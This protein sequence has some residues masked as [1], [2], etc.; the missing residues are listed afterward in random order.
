M[1]ELLVEKLTEIEMHLNVKKTKIYGDNV[2]IE[3]DFLQA[4]KTHILDVDSIHHF[5]SATF[6]NSVI[7]KNNL[8]TRPT[9]KSCIGIFLF[10]STHITSI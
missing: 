3:N 1:T 10:G 5:R 7:E 2:Q 8:G 6:T 4:D 9:S